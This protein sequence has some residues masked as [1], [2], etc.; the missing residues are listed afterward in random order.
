MWWMRARGVRPWS[1]RPPPRRRSAARPSASEIWLATA[2]VSRPPSVSVLQRADLLDSWVA[3]ALVGVERRRAARSRG[4]SGPRPGPRC[5]RWWL[6]S[7]NS[8]ISSR[9]M[10]HCSAIISAPRNWVTS[11]SPYRS[12]Q[13]VEPVN[14][15]AKPSWLA[16]GHRPSRSGSRSSSAR[17]RPR[18]GRACPHH[19]LRGEVHGLLRRAALAIDGRRRARARA[20]RRPA[21][22][23]GRCRRPARRSVS[24]QPKIDVVDRRVDP[25]R[26]TSALSAWAPRSAGCTADRPPPR[27]PTGVRTAST[28]N[29]SATAIPL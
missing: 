10:S 5:A 28:M 11:W 6:A 1:F 29:A 13:P 8:S 19:A 23:C 26:G 25:V 18:P 14:G 12:S 16:D 27:R 2:A 22:R 4:R 21:S 20:G 7:A 17:R 15:S 9:V 3:R 24:T